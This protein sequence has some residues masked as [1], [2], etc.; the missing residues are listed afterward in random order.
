MEYLFPKLLMFIGIAYI[1]IDFRVSQFLYIFI[2]WDIYIIIFRIQFCKLYPDIWPC[3]WKSYLKEFLILFPFIFN[4][5]NTELK[6]RSA[7]FTIWSLTDLD[8]IWKEKYVFK[9]GY[10]YGYIGMGTGCSHVHLDFIPIVFAFSE[11]YHPHSPPNFPF[12]WN[13]EKEKFWGQ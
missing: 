13:P 4:Y 5:L 6:V 10:G 12:N 3:F 7:S 8:K 9:H 1:S 11:S 2:D